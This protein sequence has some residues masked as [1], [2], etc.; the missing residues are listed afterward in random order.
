MIDIFAESQV[1]FS[2]FFTGWSFFRVHVNF[3][4]KF[5]HVL[6]IFE[7][8]SRQEKGGLYLLFNRGDGRGFID[9]PPL[10]FGILHIKSAL[11]H[12]I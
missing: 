6:N 4:L 12:V 9:P 10:P 1:F 2:F 3:W 11:R 7:I 8:E 5:Y